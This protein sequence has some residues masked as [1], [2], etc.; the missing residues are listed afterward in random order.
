MIHIIILTASLLALLPPAHA[1]NN[2]FSGAREITM[3][4]TRKNDVPLTRPTSQNPA[5]TY[6]SCWS[7][8]HGCT[9]EE[10]IRVCGKEPWSK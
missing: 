3:T 10:S 8:M 6:G 9:R 2:P 7:C 5:P 1:D 4:M